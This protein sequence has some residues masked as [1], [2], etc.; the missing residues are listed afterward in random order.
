[1]TKVLLSIKNSMVEGVKENKMVKKLSNSKFAKRFMATF[2]ALGGYSQL[3]FAAEPNQDGYS[4]ISNTIDMATTWTRYLGA[5][6]VV[7]GLVA[8]IMAW[9]GHNAE[10]QQNASMWLICGCMLCAIKSIVTAIGVI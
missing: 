5:L 7:Y 4:M 3:A 6:V 10:G 9:K 2:I 8:F 1:M